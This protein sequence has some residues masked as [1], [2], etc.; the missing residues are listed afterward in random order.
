MTGDGSQ[1]VQAWIEGVLARYERR[2]LGY[3]LRW[4]GDAEAARDVTQ[5]FL[6]RLCRH[7]IALDDPRLGPWLF[8]VG[9]NLAIDHLRK[10]RPMHR[11]DDLAFAPPAA[12]DAPEEG[13]AR[14]EASG[15]L[16]EQV[17][18][19]P[20]RQQEMVWLRFRGGLSYREIAEVCRTS[21][22]NVGVLLHAALRTLRARLAEA[23]TASVAKEPS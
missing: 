9:R 10:E 6:L 13:A 15:R 3:A 17:R 4:V 7:R 23:P 19:L 11:L 5:E 2:L 8:R 20:S 14:E 18:R 1:A 22:S 21:V 16:L 12:A